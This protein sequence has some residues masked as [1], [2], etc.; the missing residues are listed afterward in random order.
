MQN[1][2][3]CWAVKRGWSALR[4]AQGRRL[5]A[6]ARAQ[7]KPPGPAAARRASNRIKYVNTTM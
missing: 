2:L 4:A 1:A 3:C 5:A 6:L 7:G